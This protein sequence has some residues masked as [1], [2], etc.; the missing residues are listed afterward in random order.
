M[1]YLHQY[2]QELLGLLILL[3]FVFTIFLGRFLVENNQDTR[4][5]AAPVD[6]CT[7]QSPSLQ[8]YH[9]TH[10]TQIEP[11]SPVELTVAYIS[12]STC[13]PH[14]T[15]IDLYLK[16]ATQTNFQLVCSLTNQPSIPPVIRCPLPTTT[17][18]PNQTYHWYAQIKNESYVTKTPTQSFT[19]TQ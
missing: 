15:Q 1:F 12:P 10:Q 9:P 16:A 11:H 18:Q 13:Y 8:L 2:K 6:T 3:F 5:D 4:S 19:T 17:L 7:A 14:L